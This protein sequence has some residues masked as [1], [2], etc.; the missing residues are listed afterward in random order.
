[1]RTVKSEIR[2]S[3]S[4]TNSNI[5]KDEKPKLYDLEDRTFLFCAGRQGVCKSV[6][7]NFGQY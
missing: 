2:I 4:E 6:A 7:K 1:M 5:V 3:K